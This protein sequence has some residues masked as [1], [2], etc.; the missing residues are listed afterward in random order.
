[1][2]CEKQRQELVPLNSGGPFLQ[3]LVFVPTHLPL[4]QQQAPIPGRKVSKHF[5]AL[6]IP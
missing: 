1:M 5:V 2:L 4:R 6:P 3:T